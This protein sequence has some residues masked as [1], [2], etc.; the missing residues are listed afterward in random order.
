VADLDRYLAET[1][2]LFASSQLEGTPAPL[3]PSS[4]VPTPVL[5]MATLLDLP[6]PVVRDFF[7]SFSDEAS[8]HQW[9]ESQ[10]RP[11]TA[12]ASAATSATVAPDQASFTS[13]TATPQPAAARPVPVNRPRVSDVDTPILPAQAVA[14]SA[15]MTRSSSSTYLPAASPAVETQTQTQTQT[16]KQ[17]TKQRKIAFYP[18]PS[19]AVPSSPDLRSSQ[20]VARS[21][22]D[23]ARSRVALQ[24]ASQLPDSALTYDDLLPSFSSL[25]ASPAV[26]KPVTTKSLTAGLMAEHLNL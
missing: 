15:S 4:R 25:K 14:S 2:K 10:K 17:L 16:Q 1:D 23:L 20:D 8:F 18:P 21:N 13:L 12:P 7:D 9:L 26:K 6:G 24:L 19:T 5:K 11:A 3:L 22:Q